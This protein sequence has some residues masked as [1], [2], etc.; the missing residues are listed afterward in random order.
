MATETIA[1]LQGIS[2]TSE[3][4]VDGELVVLSIVDAVDINTNIMQRLEGHDSETRE[5][6]V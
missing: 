1:S 6:E 4:P 3:F 2:L 5:N